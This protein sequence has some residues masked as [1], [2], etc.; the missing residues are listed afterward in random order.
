MLLCINHI[1]TETN[2]WFFKDIVNKFS[3]YLS[4]CPL[5]FP[6]VTQSRLYFRVSPDE[7][8]VGDTTLRR[9]SE[10]LTNMQTMTPIYMSPHNVFVNIWMT[11][12]KPRDRIK[13]SLRGPL[14]IIYIIPLLRLFRHPRMVEILNS[15]SEQSEGGK[16]QEMSAK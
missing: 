6:N 15:T 5:K 3:Q 13:D 7:N 10:F 16:G 4:N 14:N 8:R 9:V 2:G 11:V 12:L 1:Q